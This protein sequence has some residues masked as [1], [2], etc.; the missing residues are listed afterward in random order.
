MRRAAVIILAALAACAGKDDGGDD[1]APAGEEGGGEE[2]GGEEGGGDERADADED[3]YFTPDDCDDDDPTVH[4][5]AAERCDDR[6]EDCDGDVDEYAFD[7]GTWYTDADADGYGTPGTGVVACEAPS[8]GADNN[9]DCDD[10]D[11][12]VHPD[13]E[14]LPCDDVD[15]DCDGEDAAGVL[16]AGD[17]GDTEDVTPLFAAGAAGAP[18]EVSVEASGELLLCGGTWY[19][20]ITANAPSLTITGDGATTLDADGAGA[21]ITLAEDGAVLAVSGVTLANG[22]ATVGGGIA[23][24]DDADVTLTDCAITGGSAR[25]GAAV[26]MPS[27]SL[28][29]SGCTFADNAATGDGGAIYLG[30]AAATVSDSAFSGNSAVGAGGAISV[31]ADIYDMSDWKLI[32]Y[33]S[34]FEGNSAQNGGAVY[35][36]YGLVYGEGSTFSG[37]SAGYAGGAVYTN[38]NM[39]QWE[40]CTFDG[41]SAGYGGGL[42][43]YWGTT[44]VSC[45]TTGGVTANT[46]SYGGGVYITYSGAVIV[47]GCD[48]GA[49]STDN[50]PTDVHLGYSGVTTS[51]Y[52]DDASFTC[53]GSTF[54]CY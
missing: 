9:E 31:D 15:Q 35:T 37:N 4:P 42:Y 17:G 46:A 1:T 53:S 49:D 44:Y 34:S 20:T 3:G 45:D 18:A 10:D 22:A 6:D 48:F 40:D 27:G 51:A 11:D 28:T 24:S 5:D 26:Y 23:A 25:D 14:E 50:D 39:S 38:Y 36:Y 7:A 41:N 43:G 13:A 21:N 8:G 19:A 47:D 29:V 30:S 52:G 16:F 54:T 32:V 2:G 33:D 12:G